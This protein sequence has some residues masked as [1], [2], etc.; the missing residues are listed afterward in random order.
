VF[1]GVSKQQITDS[2]LGWKKKCYQIQR[3]SFTGMLGLDNFEI[4]RHHN[5][6]I[7]QILYEKKSSELLK[8]K[9]KDINYS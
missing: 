4:T 3:S 8:K 6:D 1:K 9:P 2:Q 7:F 5:L